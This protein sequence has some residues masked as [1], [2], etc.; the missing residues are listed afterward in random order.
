MLKELQETTVGQRTRRVHVRPFAWNLHAPTHM[1]WTPDGR[2]Y[3]V[4]RTTGKI[5]DITNGGD[6][7][8]APSVVWDLE[9]PSSMCAL[10]DGRMLV[11]EFWGGRIKD[12]TEGGSAK[13]LP[14]L[15]EHLN[16][17]YS[18]TYSNSL[19][20]AVTLRDS[21]AI[22][23][24]M[25]IDAETGHKQVLVEGTPLIPPQGFWGFSPPSAWPDKYRQYASCNDWNTVVDLANSPYSI[26]LAVTD[27]VVLIPK[28]KGPYAFTELVHTHRLATGLGWTGGMIQHPF[29]DTL[30]ITL[31]HEGAVQALDLRKPDDYSFQPP[32]VRNLALASCV[33]FSQSG[34]TM[35]VCSSANGIVWEVEGAA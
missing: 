13:A 24:S 15:A 18:L 14:T 31:P 20:M 3:V 1:E 35:Y 21:I 10:P 33:R 8:S 9:G 12:I 16:G 7:D 25:L 17:P 22:G 23:K 26:A 19:G 5:M 34:E 27:M 29:N 28:G 30:F 11:T 6:M 4:E 32:V 2:L